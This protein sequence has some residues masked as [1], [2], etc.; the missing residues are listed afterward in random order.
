MCASTKLLRFAL[1]SI[2]LLTVGFILAAP[3]IAQ[4]EVG[5]PGRLRCEYLKIPEGIDLRQPRFEWVLDNS[6]RGVMQTAY[7]ILVASTPADL[8]GNRGD[9]W[10]SGKSASSDSTQVVYNGKALV[11]GHLYYWKVRSWDGQG[12]P[13][14]YS[15]TA[16]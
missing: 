11:S 7:Q 6:R 8:A 14:A 10:D 1:I 3:A 9:M 12:N 13:S 5:A 2:V 15:E 16:K 4:N